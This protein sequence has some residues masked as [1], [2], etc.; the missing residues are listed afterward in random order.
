METDM[1]DGNSKLDT[2]QSEI[3]RLNRR[4][5]NLYTILQERFPP[6]VEQGDWYEWNEDCTEIIKRRRWYE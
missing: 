5:D 4:L 6:P 1:N 3:D 2:I